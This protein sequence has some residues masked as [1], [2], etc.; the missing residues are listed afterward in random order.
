[1]SLNETLRARWLWYSLVCVLCWG[2]WTLF[3]KVGSTEIPPQTMQFL[4]TMGSLPVCI[5]LLIAR[6]F[7]LEKSPKGIFYGVLNGVLSGVGGLALFA[8]YHTNS[9][10]S[11]VT[12]ASA[13]YPMVTVLLAVIILREQLKFIQ[14]VGLGF[15][16]VAMVIFSL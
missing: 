6:G 12:A 5:A 11:L 15:A 8:A 16:A 7:K 4:F 9:N 3:S 14:V 13:L 2:G 10:T 1:M